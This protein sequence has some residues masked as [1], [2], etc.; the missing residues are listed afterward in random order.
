MTKMSNRGKLRTPL[1][2]LLHKKRGRFFCKPN[3]EL[4]IGRFDGYI[5]TYIVKTRNF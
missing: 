4:N 5:H 2:P 3:K 1:N